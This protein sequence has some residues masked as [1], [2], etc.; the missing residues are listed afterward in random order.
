MNSL[1]PS[2]GFCDHAVPLSET[3][4]FR[5][6]LTKSDNADLR[7]S[8]SAIL[9]MCWALPLTICSRASR[10]SRALCSSFQ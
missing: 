2:G 3:S 8:T 9:S 6:S 7:F 10:M 1:S 5:D 4:L